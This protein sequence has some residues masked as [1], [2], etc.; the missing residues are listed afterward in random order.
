M[1]Q[2]VQTLEQRWY[3]HVKAAKSS[4]RL[5]IHCAIRKY[6]AEAFDK[7][8]LSSASDLEELD[9]LECHFIAQCNSITPNGYNRTTGGKGFN[10][11]HTEESRRKMRQSHLGKKQ[12]PIA[13]QK[14]R[15]AVKALWQSEPERWTNFNR[16]GQHNSVD[17]RKKQSEATKKQWERQVGLHWTLTPEQRANIAAANQGR[18]LSETHKQAIRESL[19]GR[20]RS[21][22]AVEKQRNTIA[23]QREKI[24]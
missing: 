22:E 8:Q 18:K 13:V 1:G 5:P 10:G 9:A 19:K 21:P 24:Q 16:R 20:K 12:S 3:N 2:T 23:N 6:G 15:D 17:H 7:S 4:S 14:Q 11:R